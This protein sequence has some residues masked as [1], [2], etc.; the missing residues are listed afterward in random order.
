MLQECLMRDNQRKFLWRT[1]GR[2]R[3]QSGKRKRYKDNPAASLKDFNIPTE[4]WEHAAQDRAKWHYLIRNGAAQYD[5]KRVC[6]AERRNAKP[7]PRD[8]HQSRYSQSSHT[9][10]ATGSLELKLT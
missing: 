4:F 9:L 2:N 7:Q 8:H 6:E 1:A 5:V 3:S 10:R